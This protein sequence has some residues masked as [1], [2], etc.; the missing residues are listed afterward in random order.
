MLKTLKSTLDGKSILSLGRPS[1]RLNET[2]RNLLVKL[3]IQPLF[4]SDQNRQFT[5]KEL[6]EWSLQIQELF[7]L[8]S[9][10]LYYTPYVA[11]HVRAT[12]R[13][14]SGKLLRFVYNRRRQ[15]REKGIIPA[16]PRARSSS[17]SSSTSASSQF[18]ESLGDEDIDLEQDTADKITWLK[19]S[20]EPWHLVEENWL[21]TAKYRLRCNYE[22]PGTL[23]E[24]F[25]EYPVLKRPTGYL[26]LLKDFEVL[27]KDKVDGLY[28]N[29]VNLRK[30]VIDLAKQKG[31]NIR[32]KDIKQN[33]NN[34]VSAATTGKNFYSYKLSIHKCR[35]ING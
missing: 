34:Y 26:L 27:H 15:L 35:Q 16:S 13:N 14:A 4:E 17:K 31:T 11:A 3:L 30:N 6:L 33:I 7:P 24:Y 21:A 19:N 23:Q 18:L 9:A 12:A 22:K 29:I 25:E 20:L 10:A 2:Q 28:T 1:G 8:E 5:N 32:D